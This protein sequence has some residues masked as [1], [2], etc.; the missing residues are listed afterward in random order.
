MNSQL[1]VGEREISP[2]GFSNTEEG[3]NG[4]SIQDVNDTNTSETLSWLQYSP[5][6]NSFAFRLR[7]YRRNIALA[8]NHKELSEKK[9]NHDAFCNKTQIK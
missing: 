9:T 2:L 8:G 3:M 5:E 6:V 4:Q 7:K 1:L